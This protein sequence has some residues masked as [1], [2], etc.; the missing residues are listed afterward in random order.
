[1]KWFGIGLRERREW[2][3]RGFTGSVV[4]EGAKSGGELPEAA[5]Q[6]VQRILRFR[7]WDAQQ[8]GPFKG[9]GS[10]PGKF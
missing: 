3:D 8:E 1:M 10:Q 2:P 4:S 7:R 6:E 9:F 5:V